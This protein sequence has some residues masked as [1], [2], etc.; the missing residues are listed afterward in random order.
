MITT[1]ASL[2]LA[3]VGCGKSAENAAEQEEH[4]RKQSDFEQYIRPRHDLMALA[5]LYL[6]W[7]EQQHRPPTAARDLQGR[8]PL[9]R[10]A[11]NGLSA[12]RYALHWGL[13]VRWLHHADRAQVVLGYQAT[14]TERG[15]RWV[16]MAD[17]EARELSEKDFEQVM[18]RQRGAS[19]PSR[20]Q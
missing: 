10:R 7:E 17:A 16:V 20:R 13:E 4:A 6:D 14:S 19:S 1:L 8:S 2:E 18:V 11:L 15:T 12:G 9:Q 5:C 3:L